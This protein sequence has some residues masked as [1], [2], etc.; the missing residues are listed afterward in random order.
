MHYANT[1]GNVNAADDAKQALEHCRKISP[2]LTPEHYESMIREMSATTE[3][4]DRRVAGLRNST[5]L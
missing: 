4:G 5:I 2:A 1:L 3:T